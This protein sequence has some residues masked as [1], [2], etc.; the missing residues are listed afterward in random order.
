MNLETLLQDEQ[1]RLKREVYVLEKEIET[2]KETP[3]GNTYPP[4]ARR[5]LARK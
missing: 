5:G 2:A 1:T 3:T 4:A